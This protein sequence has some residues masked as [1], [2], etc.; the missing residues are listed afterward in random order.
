MPV[1]AYCFSIIKHPTKWTSDNI[2]QILEFGNHL[3][4]DSIN[5]LHLHDAFVR[6]NS[7]DL[8]KYCVVGK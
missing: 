8:L 3:C 4:Q 1:A 6:I 2:D 5:S 7:Q